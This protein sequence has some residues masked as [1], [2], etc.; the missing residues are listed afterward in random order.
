MPN[1]VIENLFI[2]DT[3]TETKQQFLRPA[4]GKDLVKIF[5]DFLDRTSDE[6]LS[7]TKTGMES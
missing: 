3:D 4:T 7:Q 5:K 1:K 2:R 6:I